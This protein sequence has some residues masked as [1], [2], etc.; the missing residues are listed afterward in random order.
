MGVALVAVLA[1]A[2]LGGSSSGKR[3][4]VM[5]AVARSGGRAWEQSGLE[6]LAPSPG[7]LLFPPGTTYARALRSIYLAQAVALPIDNARLVAP[8]PVGV[9]LKHT[10]AGGL[11]IDLAA[12]HGY[13]PDSLA[14]V[15]PVYVPAKRRTAERLPAKFRTSSPHWPRGSALATPK[16][17]ACEVLVP[18]KA[19]RKCTK[20]ASV[21]LGGP[22]PALPRPD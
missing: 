12:P 21:A 17:P 14:V 19:H 22:G 8:L 16:L 13:Q 1:P 3:D 10:R 18:G 7:A 9:V 20:T 2:A 5:D 6:R 11:V 4:E 15:E